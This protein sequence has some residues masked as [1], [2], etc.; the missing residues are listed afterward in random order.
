V[1][2][3]PAAV[4]L[5]ALVTANPGHSATPL[6]WD[7]PRAGAGKTFLDHVSTT[8]AEEPLYS[9]PVN[10]QAGSSAE[11]AFAEPLAI[12]SPSAA[13]ATNDET[14][15]MLLASLMGMAYL[16]LRRRHRS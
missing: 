4:L 10:F 7:A 15:A 11:S 2:V 5:A 1:N 9:P 13:R 8:Y 6:G 16:G 3:A 12:T 14:Y